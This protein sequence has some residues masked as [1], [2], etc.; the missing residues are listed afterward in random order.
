MQNLHQVELVQGPGGCAKMQ[1]RSQPGGYLREILT[2][3]VYDVA[4]SQHV[5]AAA[6]VSLT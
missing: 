5:S 6:I 4:V 3:R 1:W 2:A